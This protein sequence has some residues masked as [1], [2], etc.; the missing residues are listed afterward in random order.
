MT[1]LSRADARTAATLFPDAR[2][3][4]ILDARSGPAC[5]VEAFPRPW[6]DGGVVVVPRTDP[7]PEGPVVAL[8]PTGVVTETV[9]AALTPVADRPFKVLA[10]GD[11]LLRFSAPVP[12][13]PT[14]PARPVRLVIEGVERVELTTSTFPT[15]VRVVVPAA[16]TQR[17]LRIG[18]A[19][20]GSEL[21]GPEWF[22]LELPPGPGE[23]EV[24]VAPGRDKD[25]WV[26]RRAGREVG[27][28]TVPAEPVPVRR[29]IL[30]FDRTCPD[31]N[32]WEAARAL[33]RGD[34]TPGEPDVSAFLTTS[35]IPSGGLAAAARFPQAELNAAIR[36][37][38]ADGFRDGFG[39]GVEV[40]LVWFA[41]VPGAMGAPAGVTVLRTPV[42]RGDRRCPATELPDLLAA[43][44]YAPGLDLWDALE[45]AVREAARVGG[46][47]PAAVLIVGNSPPRPPADPDHPFTQ[48]WRTG[49]P[50]STVR[51]RGAFPDAL[52]ALARVGPVLTIF[53]GG[54]ELPAVGADGYQT[55]QARVRDAF[56]EILPVIEAVADRA[57]VARA[58]TL[59]AKRLSGWTSGVLVWEGHR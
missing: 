20:P 3:I 7:A 31:R 32:R 55:I 24:D 18:P 50:P 42:G 58:V 17:L 56:A 40:E 44:G 15:T 2:A 30:I 21:P 38:L 19:D 28:P 45:E 26:L 16:H 46:N 6:A 36:A 59:A 13:P 9:R 37:G 10:A 51:G 5:W 27:H 23:L 29:V 25:R 52:D 22:G 41:D 53:L 1:P 48:L 12:R 14:R 47:G 4:N 35:S 11:S 34:R 49:L 39:P 57:G 8:L 33:V 43:G 54:H